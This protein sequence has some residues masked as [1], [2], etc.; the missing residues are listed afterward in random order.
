MEHTSSIGSIESYFPLV[1]KIVHFEIRKLSIRRGMFE[2]IRSF[3]LEGLVGASQSFDS[4][5]GVPFEPYAAKRIRWSIYDGLRTAGW[6]PRHLLNK[7]KFLHKAEELLDA[8]SND[9]K[10]ADKNEAALR[11]ADA[12]KDLAA[13]YVVSYAEDEPWKEHSVPAEADEL[14]DKKRIYSAMHM[15]VQ[16]LP[17]KERWVIEQHFYKDRRLTDIAQDMNVT[18]S[19]ASR[20]LSSGLRH[21]HELFEHAEDVKNF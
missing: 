19:W 2:E 5:R 3:A 10:P 20:L 4:D 9:P 6:F 13:V 17:Q 1:D 11:F 21:L 14:V 12:V 16:S 18:I 8:K 7:V 15:Y